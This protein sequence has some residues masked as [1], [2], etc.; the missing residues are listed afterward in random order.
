MAATR[1]AP[2]AMPHAVRWL[3]SR[4]SDD[5]TTSRAS[6]RVRANSARVILLE[7]SVHTIA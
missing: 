1:N 3:T 4:Y 7:R 5:L 2:A 6:S